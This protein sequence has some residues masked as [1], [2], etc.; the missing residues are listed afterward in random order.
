[1]YKT[2]IITGA[3]R[4]IGKETAL[5][6]AKN[7]LNIVVCSRTQGEIDCRGAHINAANA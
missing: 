4:G 3:G 5:L 7:D 2:A 1:M 6:L